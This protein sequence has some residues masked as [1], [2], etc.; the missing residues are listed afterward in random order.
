M[1]VPTEE[2]AVHMFARYYRARFKDAAAKRAR[3]TANSLAQKGDATG[4]KMWNEV[5]NTIDR[6]NQ[7]R[8]RKLK[9]QSP[10]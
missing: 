2:E 6:H 8:G 1:W 10:H 5:A 3:E 7:E 4:Q 9:R